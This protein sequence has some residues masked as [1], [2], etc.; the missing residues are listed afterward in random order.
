MNQCIEK[1]NMG[2]GFPFGRL[3]G[4]LI[5]IVFVA[6][7][8][9]AQRDSAQRGKHRKDLLQLQPEQKA[10]VDQ[11]RFSFKKEAMTFR[12]QLAEKKARLRILETADQPD[13]KNIFALID[14]ISGLRTQFEKKEAEMKQSIRK[15]LTP[16]QRLVFDLKKDKKRKEKGH[17]HGHRGHE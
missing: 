17:K 12:N 4:I 9:S 15:I 5:V 2:I 14:E 7:P 8:V 10:K 13:M 1:S 6:H 11:I 3:L 16:E